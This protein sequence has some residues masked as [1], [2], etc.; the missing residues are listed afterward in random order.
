ME[1]KEPNVLDLRVSDIRMNFDTHTIGITIQIPLDLLEDDKQSLASLSLI[2][3][4][5][6]MIPYLKDSILDYKKLQEFV[7]RGI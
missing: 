3:K 2:A 5:I 6:N 1:Y 7:R 4:L